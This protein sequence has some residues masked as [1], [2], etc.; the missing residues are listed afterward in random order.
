MIDIKSKVDA[1]MRAIQ[2]KYSRIIHVI[3]TG[4]MPGQDYH[5]IDEEQQ[6]NLQELVG[7]VKLLNYAGVNVFQCQYGKGSSYFSKTNDSSIILNLQLKNSRIGL[8]EI[9]VSMTAQANKPNIVLNNR[10]FILG[11]MSKMYDDIIGD[12][13]HNSRRAIELAQQYYSISDHGTK[14]SI[15]EFIKGSKRM[16]TATRKFLE[17]TFARNEKGRLAFTSNDMANSLVELFYLDSQ[18]GNEDTLSDQHIKYKYG[19]ID[20]VCTQ[21]NDSIK[22][23]IQ[24]G[25]E[26]IQKNASLDSPE[27]LYGCL[28]G[29]AIKY[30]SNEA[31]FT[32]LDYNEKIN[33]V[34]NFDESDGVTP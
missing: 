30:A 3:N 16:P 19:A 1:H 12:N 9:D 11:E 7:M 5:C 18:F 15:D 22:G 23:T 26:L 34:S 27:S 28:V 4:K 10:M 13:F 32:A 25:D 31:L 2:N 21:M 29:D 8:K 6:K 14:M 20:W 17:K 24:A 33:G